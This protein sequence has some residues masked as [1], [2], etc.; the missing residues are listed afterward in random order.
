MSELVNHVAQEL[1]LPATRL[2]PTDRFDKELAPAPGWEWDSGTGMLTLELKRLAKEKGVQIDFTE[3]VTLN[4]YIRV[5]AR[6]WD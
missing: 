2:L 4:D 1:S 6:V 3:I 5:A